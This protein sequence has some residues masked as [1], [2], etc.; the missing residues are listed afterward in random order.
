MSFVRG[1][2]LAG[3][4]VILGFVD[5]ENFRMAFR[6]YNEFLT[7][8][9]II[10]AFQEL[11]AEL[12][13]LRTIFFY[14]DWTRRP[15]DA[16]TIEEHGH[17]AVNVLSTRYG[18][19]RSD[20]PMGFD[21]YDHA[22]DD[23]EVSAFI[24]GSGD[25]GFKEAILRCKQHGK[26]IYVLCFGKS[27]ARELFTLTNSVYPLEARLGLTEKLPTQPVPGVPAADETIV[28]RNLIEVVDSVEKSIPYIVRN[29]L[30]DKV[31]LPKQ[32]FG[33]TAQEIDELL[34]K[35]IQEKIL[36]VEEIP[37]PK[38]EDRT[39]LTIRLNRSS[40][41]VKEVLPSTN[42]EEAGTSPASS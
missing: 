33:E 14:G 22:K 17:R 37:N 25:S 4:E 27:A 19:D 21:M 12:G 28:I 34:D 38:I 3:K 8:E 10:D 15:Q 1:T 35:A 24:V 41:S 5:Y 7:V 9:H 11:G 23:R 16:R 30:R 6:N 26:R 18:K 32:K 40:G 13:D 39:V 36:L 20:F 42:N 29:Y 2:Q 31:L